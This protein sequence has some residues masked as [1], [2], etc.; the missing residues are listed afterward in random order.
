[1]AKS[2]SLKEAKAILKS[3]NEAKREAVE[4]ELAAIGA[5]ELTDILSWD[6]NGHTTMLASDQLTEKAKR[7]IKKMKV[8]PTQYGN[9]L[10]V[11]MYDK[12]AALR[13]LAKHYGMLNV[14]T[15][16]NRPSVLGINIKGPETV[17]DVR[18]KQDD[19]ET[20]QEK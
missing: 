10:E 16:Q 15:S 12:I 11:E 20:E 8:T 19:E 4:Q 7:S 13:L 14:D 5:S 9:Q 17:Y 18:E 1:M 2:L 3:P 6:S